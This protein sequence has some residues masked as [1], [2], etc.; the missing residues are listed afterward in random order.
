[1]WRRIYGNLHDVL[2]ETMEQFNILIILLFVL[3]RSVHQI[4]FLF[5]NKKNRPKSSCYL[6]TSP[7]FGVYHPTYTL[8]PDVLALNVLS[9]LDFKILQQDL[10][11]LT[12]CSHVYIFLKIRRFFLRFWTDLRPHIAYLNRFHLSTRMHKTGENSILVI[13]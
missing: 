1:M 9:A 12:P 7:R 5:H 10:I 2:W 4:V 8:L 6:P 13:S 3:Y 11:A